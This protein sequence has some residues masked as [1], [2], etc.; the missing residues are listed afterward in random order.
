MK[1]YIDKEDAIDILFA[2]FASHWKLDCSTVDDMIQRKVVHA[3]NKIKETPAADVVER[4][5][6]DTGETESKP[7]KWLRGEAALAK[8]ILGTIPGA[9]ALCRHTDGHPYLDSAWDC[10]D[11]I[12]VL[13]HGEES[14]TLFSPHYFPSLRPNEQVALEYIINNTEEVEHEGVH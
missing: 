3:K 4:K 14:Q 10:V 11:T 9:Y 7:H 12:L 2:A 5:S 6:S 13:I 8:A 1:E